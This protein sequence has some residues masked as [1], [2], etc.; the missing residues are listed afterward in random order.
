MYVNTI[1]QFLAS[2]CLQNHGTLV[3]IFGLLHSHVMLVKSISNTIIVDTKED[4]YTN[5]YLTLVY[6][7]DFTSVHELQ[8]AFRVC[9]EY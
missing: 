3:L 8:V 4:I 6:E 1:L 7:L 5:Y 2:N 9:L